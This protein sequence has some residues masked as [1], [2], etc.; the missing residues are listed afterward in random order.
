[1]DEWNRF[2]ERYGIDIIKVIMRSR[3][4]PTQ[5]P[6]V[7]RSRIG[8]CCLPK[9]EGLGILAYKHI[10][11]FEDEIFSITP[12]AIDFNDNWSLYSD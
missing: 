1:M 3:C 8:G 5:Q 11:G 7:P 4:G 10:H 9:D 2:A 12:K 6:D